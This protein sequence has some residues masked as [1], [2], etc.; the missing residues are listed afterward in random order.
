MLNLW[1]NR[2]T[3]DGAFILLNVL[4]ENNIYLSQITLSDNLIEEKTILEVD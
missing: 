4:L 2:I 1:C 3:D